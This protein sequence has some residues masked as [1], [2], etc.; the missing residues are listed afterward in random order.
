VLNAPAILVTWFLGSETGP[1]IAE[2]LFGAEGPS[3]RLP[4]SFPL[5]SGQ[6]PYYYAHKPSGRPNR[7]SEIEA[8]KKRYRDT[9][10][11]AQFAFGHGLTYGRIE[12]SDLDVSSRMLSW[13]GTLSVRATVSN[14]GSRAAVEVAQLYIRDVAASVTRPVREL[15]GYQRVSLQPGESKEVTFT[16]SRRD[17]MFVGRDLRPTAEAG[18]FYLWVAPSAEAEGLVGRFVLTADQT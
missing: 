12:Y 14:R 15:K 5:A 3:G 17:L 8:Y 7:S 18:E 11:V 6:T 13:N 10:Y 16:L 9:L 2:I 4:V 1:A